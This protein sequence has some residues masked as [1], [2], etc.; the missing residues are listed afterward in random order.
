MIGRLKHR[1]PEGSGY[2]QDEHAVLGHTRLSIIDLE[3]GWQPLSNEDGSMWV[4]YN[5]EIFNYVELAAELTGHGHVFRTRSDTEVIVHAFEQWG[6]RCFERFNGQWALAL[7]DRRNRSLVLS[8]DRLGVRPLFYARA[9][10]R[11]HFASEIK[12]LFADPRIDR[13]FDSAGLEEIFT[14]WCTVAP[15]TAFAGVSQLE[16]GC[17]AVLADGKLQT[18]PYWRISFPPAAR[19]SGCGL[20]E[21]GAVLRERL[22]SAARLRFLRSD[23]PVGAYLS[24]G[25]DSSVT[26]AIIARY[27]DAPLET[28][29]LQ[30]TDPEFDERAYQEEMSKRLGSRH[31]AVEVAAEE[32]GRSFPEVIWHAEQPLLRSAPAPMYL[33]SRLVRQSGFKV[34]VTG[35][36]ADEMLAGYDIF[37]EAK[38]RIFWSR[39]PESKKRGDIAGL[40]YPWME[41]TP[42]KAPSFAHEFFAR[43]LDAA[44]AALSHRPRWDSAAGITSLL[45]ADA[46]A[47]LAGI[48]VADEL[49]AG[50]PAEHTE[51]D[52]LC[53]AQWLEIKTLLS[54]YILSAQG[55]RMLMANSVEGRFP[56]LDPE[57]VA[58]AN[59]LPARHKL[60]ALDEKH[61]LKSEFADMIPPSILARPKQP[62]R[63]P[64]A[65]SFFS[66]G[67]VDWVRDVTDPRC[68]AAA[69][70]FEPAAVARLLAKCAQAGGKRMSNTDNMR[71]LA[72]LSTMLVHRTFI[73]ADG[74]G[75]H[76][77]EPDRKSV[78]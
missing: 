2:F 65:S 51:W 28:F 59:S 18:I 30:F 44:D 55:D 64:E 68:L 20:R 70:I 78:V 53:R 37:R 32:I 7:W 73:A 31:H 47:R 41:R 29:S 23:V 12:A 6:M 58:F 16:P 4:S 56:F 1:G 10:G 39:D 40:L 63:A 21:N 60:L 38:V 49:I 75:G 15:R 61:I 26:A 22:V 8:R 27:T 66:R 34:V 46:R 69:G 24:G 77:E 36:G 11:F 19:D 54:G 25:I 72:V 13:R 48:P 17:A 14:F 42:G 5:G 9:G 43:N 57:L 52:P 62:Y 74:S 35:E 76:D 3:G 50:M 71:L 33:L 45:T 67:A